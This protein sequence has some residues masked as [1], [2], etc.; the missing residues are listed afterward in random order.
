MSILTGKQVLKPYIKKTTGYIKS[1][2]SSQHVE[3]NNGITLQSN[4]DQINNNLTLL[5]NKLGKIEDKIT[6]Y[7]TFNGTNYNQDEKKWKLEPKSA[8]LFTVAG[9]DNGD[10][11]SNLVGIYII[12]TGEA[13]TKKAHITALN[14]GSDA[15]TISVSEGYLVYPAGAY[16]YCMFSLTR[17]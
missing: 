7:H 5:N 3:M 4:V 17:L 11:A 9:V 1:L 6:S 10:V 16:P 14:R 15:V 2:L 13:E 12:Q 8:Y